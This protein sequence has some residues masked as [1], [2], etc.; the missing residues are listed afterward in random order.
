[1]DGPHIGIGWLRQQNRQGPHHWQKSLV[2][3][4]MLASNEYLPCNLVG[5][6]FNQFN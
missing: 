5:I 2:L 4:V 1:M 3:I 6:R